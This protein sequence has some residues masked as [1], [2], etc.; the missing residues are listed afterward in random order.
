MT[1]S[2]SVALAPT[3]AVDLAQG[4]VHSTQEALEVATG[5]AELAGMVLLVLAGAAVAPLLLALV[6]RHRHRHVPAAPEPAPHDD[7]GLDALAE[8]SRADGR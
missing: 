7:R 8:V 5:V 3:L 2:L 1:A 4:T 6:G